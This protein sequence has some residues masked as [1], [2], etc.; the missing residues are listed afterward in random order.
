MFTYLFKYMVVYN[1]MFVYMLMSWSCLG[2]I[3]RTC[4][5]FKYMFM[6]YFTCLSSTFPP[7]LPSSVLSTRMRAIISANQATTNQNKSI[8]SNKPSA[9]KMASSRWRENWRERPALQRA[10]VFI[11]YLHDPNNIQQTILAPSALSL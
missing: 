6:Y 5:L 7:P 10:Q 11:E 3:L 8:F 2:T 9:N 4:L 1:Y